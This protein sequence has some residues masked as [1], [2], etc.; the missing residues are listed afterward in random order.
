MFPVSTARLRMAARSLPASGS[1]QPWHQIVLARGHGGEDSAPA[2]RGSR[3][4]RGWGRGGRSRSGRP[5]W[6]RRP[7]STPPRRSATPRARRPGRR[8]PRAT[9]PPT[10]GRRTWSAPR[11]GGPRS[12]RRCRA[13]GAAPARSTPRGR[14]ASS[15]ARASARNSSCS[16]VNAEV[17]AR[18][19]SDTP[20]DLR[21]QSKGPGR[22]AFV[23]KARLG[24][25]VMPNARDRRRGAHPGGAPQRQV[26]G[27]ARRGPRRRTRSRPSSSAT[28]STPPW[29][30][31]SSWAAP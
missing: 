23:P 4:R 16:G 21:Q 25:P 6:A 17:H 1:D 19:E 28:T 11:P 13:R 14:V 22:S 18:V 12:P 24:R 8:T 29:S 10:S 27:L 2:A 26:V 7:G 15:Q 3:T 5:G 9:T 30:R 31:T 20:P